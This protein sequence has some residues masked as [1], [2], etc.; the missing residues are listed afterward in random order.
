MARLDHLVNALMVDCTYNVPLLPEVYFGLKAIKSH[1]LAV[2]NKCSYMYIYIHI[3]TNCTI[4]I[5][6]PQ[7]FSREVNGS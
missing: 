4:I 5:A 1:A 7:L 3:L 6:K 2:L